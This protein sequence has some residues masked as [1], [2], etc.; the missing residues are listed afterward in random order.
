MKILALA[1]A[2]TEQRGVHRKLAEQLAA[3]RA[4]GASVESVVFADTK[5][6]PVPADTPY[7]L[8]HVPGGGFAAP[9]RAAAFHTC[10][11]L[12][13]DHA[14]DVVYMRYPG[15]DAHAARFTRECPVVFETQTIFAREAPPLAEL[16]ERWARRLLPHAAG[17]VAVT[18]EILAYDQAR[19]GWAIPGH[20]MPNGA[21]P[22]TIPFTEPR[23]AP[24]RVDVLCV[25]S[26]YPWHG[27][28]R[29]M[30]GMALEPEVRDVHLHLV[31]EGPMVPMLRDLAARTGI[32]DR[33]HFH[34]DVPV[35][36][37]DRHYPTAHVAVGSLAPHRVGLRELAAL[38]HREYAL[39]GLPMVI[40]GGD[41]DFPASLPWMRQFPADDSPVSPR[42]LR[43]LALGW[44][45]E[46]RRRQIRRWAEAHVS[47]AAKV[48]GLLAFLGTLRAGARRGPSLTLQSVA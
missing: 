46:P 37:L 42:T 22:D 14:P 8:I 27:I 5:G 1:F 10:W 45:A 6:A 35:S 48:P 12:V 18:P 34:G 21:D 11:E 38:K 28:D 31:G 39:R 25:A 40:G 43:A 20:V 17:L 41:A 23:L 47:W 29:L 19:A 15:F 13:Q 16:E 24:G 36:E 33:V 44:A 4:A 26:F 32:A 2:G 30:A 9:W 3:L 7:R